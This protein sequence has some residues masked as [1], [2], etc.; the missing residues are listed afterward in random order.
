MAAR[1]KVAPKKKVKKKRSKKKLILTKELKKIFLGILILVAVVLTCAMIADIVFNLSH[2]DIE[3]VAVQSVPSETKKAL[4]EEKVVIDKEDP[5]QTTLVKTLKP[6]KDLK[7]KTRDII[8]YEI[9]EDL[10][11]PLVPTIDPPKI[12]SDIPQIAIIIDDVGYDRKTVTLLSEIDENITFSIL[13]QAPFSSQIAKKLHKKG[14][15]LMLHLPMEPMEYPQINPGP[16]ALL[17]NMAPD[18]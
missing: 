8:K 1:K 11:D 3:S 18:I 9:F 12:K 4:P 10:H 6:S 7:E 5:E 13:P 2:V 15:Q 17:S 16:G 14:Y